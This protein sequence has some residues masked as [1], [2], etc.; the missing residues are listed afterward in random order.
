MLWFYR[1]LYAADQDLSILVL[2]KV[3]DSFVPLD[4]TRLTVSSCF[5]SV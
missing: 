1:R 3:V 4:R 5:Q 2:L